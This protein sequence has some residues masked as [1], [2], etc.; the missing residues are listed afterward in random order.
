MS[1]ILKK[2]LDSQSQQDTQALKMYKRMNEK[3][4]QASH[5]GI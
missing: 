2:G 1:A 5:G 3:V 4:R